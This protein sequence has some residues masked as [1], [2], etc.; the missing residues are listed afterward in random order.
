MCGQV[1]FDVGVKNLFDVFLVDSKMTALSNISAASVDDDHNSVGPTSN[2][3]PFYSPWMS[4]L[5]P[6]PTKWHVFVLVI[7][8]DPTTPNSISVGSPLLIHGL[9]HFFMWWKPLQL[10]KTFAWSSSSLQL[11]SSCGVGK[12]T[13]GSFLT[14]RW[15]AQIVIFSWIFPVRPGTSPARNRKMGNA[16]SIG[17]GPRIQSRHSSQRM[18]YYSRYATE[19]KDV[20]LGVPLLRLVWSR[21]SSQWKHHFYWNWPENSITTLVSTDGVL[22]KICNWKEGC[23]AWSSVA[24]T[25]HARTL[26]MLFF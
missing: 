14:G 26:S 7:L 21:H 3:V 2:C 5:L 4:L 6:W 11:V 8:G 25:G 10:Y 9:E 19:M 12:S 20:V 18:A 17:I 13:A 16:I 23:H 22:L 24:R 1:R 15:V